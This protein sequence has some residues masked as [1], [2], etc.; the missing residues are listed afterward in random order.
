MT[1]HVAKESGDSEMT[2][3]ELKVEQE[4]LREKTERK[5]LEAFWWGAVIIWAGL[6][7]IA[8]YLGVLPN[9]REAGAWSWIFLGAGVFGLI[10][11]VIRV[12]SDGLP[13]PTGWD[14]FWSALFLIIGASGFVGGGIAF[15]IVLIVIGLA[16]LGN[17][18]FRRD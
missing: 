3:E 14:Y 18:L 1:E 2:L 8:D 5:R 12:A 10:G 17:V 7:F 4:M 15:P 11:A 9:I 6:V 13:N 16:I